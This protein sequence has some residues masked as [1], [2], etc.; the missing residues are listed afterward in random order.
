LFLLLKFANEFATQAASAALNA[1]EF[2][3]YMPKVLRDERPAGEKEFSPCLAG[4]PPIR[5]AQ[6]HD[7]S[8]ADRGLEYGNNCTPFVEMTQAGAAI[9]QVLM[10]LARRQAP[11]PLYNRLQAASAHDMLGYALVAA[12][13]TW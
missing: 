12:R 6:S 11:R 2:A 13:G 4:L 1:A 5:P 3:K 7:N 9:D 8:V 10:G